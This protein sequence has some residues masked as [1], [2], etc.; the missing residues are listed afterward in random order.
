MNGEK[1]ALRSSFLRLRRSI[2]PD[3]K[4]LMDRKIG[5]RVLQSD[6]YQ[7]AQ[8]VFCYVSLPNEVD[9]RAIFADAWRRGKQIA[10]PRCCEQGRMDFFTVTSWDDLAA[11][12][13][14]ILEPKESCPLCLPQPD[15]LC[16]LP[17]LAADERGFRLGY[18]GG[19]YD[20]YLSAHPVRT[21]GLCYASFVVSTLPTEPFDVPIQMR[22]S[23][24]EV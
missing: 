1:D 14:G 4:D 16:I 7:T 8:T 23:D 18:G 22:I 6:A 13:R 12:M 15:D 2:P 24:K 19:Y 20:R 11:G 10:A 5:S 3:K 21:L 17:C 9:T